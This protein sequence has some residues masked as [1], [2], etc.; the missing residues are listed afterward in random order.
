[1]PVGPDG[2]T[3]GS[4]ARLSGHAVH[5]RIPIMTITPSRWLPAA[6]WIA[7]LGGVLL[8]VACFYPGQMNSDSLHQLWQAR[9]G[10]YNDWHPPI[11]SWWW[12]LIDLVIPGPLGVLLFH[13]LLFWFGLASLLQDRLQPLPAAAYTLLIGLAPSC[14]ALL[15]TI[16]KDVGLGAA[17]LAA[18]ALINQYRRSRSWYFLC[19]AAALLFYGCAVRKNAATAIMPMAIWTGLL[20]AGNAAT[21]AQRWRSVLYSNWSRAGDVLDLPAG[22]CGSDPVAENLPVTGDL[23]ARSGLPFRG[24]A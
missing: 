18:V 2:P 8:V 11:M 10:L 23:P 3:G 7:A 24:L 6:P 19:G 13:S 20:W 9:T 4:S 12:R 22:E 1:M 16:W 5:R 15:G 17:L 21:P 14:F